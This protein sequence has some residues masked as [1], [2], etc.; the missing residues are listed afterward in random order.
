M[1]PGEKDSLELKKEDFM[2]GG[3]YSYL[4]IPN[5]PNTNND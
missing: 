1:S 5:C 2:D 3:K 4:F